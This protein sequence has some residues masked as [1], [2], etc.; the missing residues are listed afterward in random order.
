MFIIDTHR[1]SHDDEQVDLLDP[2]KDEGIEEPS[3]GDFIPGLQQP[4]LDTAEA[5]ER[6]VL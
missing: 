5:F 6:H 3:G 2:G 1:P 4:I